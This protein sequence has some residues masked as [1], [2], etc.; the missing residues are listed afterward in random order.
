MLTE[1]EEEWAPPPGLTLEPPEAPLDSTAA[2]FALST[3]LLTSK[4]LLGL[5]LAVLKRAHSIPSGE[6]P[7]YLKEEGSRQLSGLDGELL[8]SMFGLL[9]TQGLW[10]MAWP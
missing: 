6:L 3:A 2:W 1:H 4:G 5:W 7:L 10:P 9:M 8:A